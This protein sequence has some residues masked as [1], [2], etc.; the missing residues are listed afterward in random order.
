MLRTVLEEQAKLKPAGP[1]TLAARIVAAMS[2]VGGVAKAG[3]NKDQGYA[4]QTAADI[5]EATQAAFGRHGVLLMPD[6]LNIEWPEPMV[7]GEGKWMFICRITMLYTLRDVES[8]ES[9]SIKSTGLA[10][11]TSDK[12][13]NKA[14]TFALKTFLKQLLLI[15]EEEDDGDAEHIEPAAEPA[16]P[17]CGVVGAI[18][19]G[20]AEYGG[21]WLCFGKKGG[22]GAKF[23]KDPRETQPEPKADK[24]AKAAPKSQPTST[25]IAE[26]KEAAAPVSEPAADTSEPEDIEK[27]Q[28]QAQELEA[29]AAALKWPGGWGKLLTQFG[30]PN[31]KSYA[32]LPDKKRQLLAKTLEDRQKM[33]DANQLVL[34]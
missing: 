25:P 24:P 4:Y 7:R 9:V 22:C 2:D 28:I 16:C 6:E 30:G 32:D 10:F 18:I 14:K 5:F 3:R 15:G 12:A 34:K 33:V 21:G 23:D 11:D 31:A 20:K 8:N 1:K 26:Q 17:S 27:L 13:L 19:K 29:W